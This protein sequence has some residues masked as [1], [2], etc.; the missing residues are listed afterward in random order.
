M[1]SAI[2]IDKLLGLITLQDLGRLHAQS[3]GFSASGACDENA[4][5]A[6]N[7]LIRNKPTTP[8]LE[9]ALL[10]ETI[11]SIENNCSII[12]TGADCKAKR[13]H[14]E[15]LIKQ[16]HWQILELTKGD[17]LILN[18][19]KRGVYSYIAIKGGINASIWLNSAS[20]N[21]NE[22][23]LSFT[24]PLLKVG[25]SVYQHNVSKVIAPFNK[26]TPIKKRGNSSAYS[27]KNF[28]TFNYRNEPLTL[29]FL[30]S[31]LFWQLPLRTQNHILK[32]MYK[33]DVRCNRMGVRIKAQEAIKFPKDMPMNTLSQP[34]TLGTVQ[35]PPD[36]FPIILMKDR[37]TI[38]GY[39]V[40]GS[41]IQVD[42]FRLSQCSPNQYIKLA[43]TDI[44]FAQTQLKSFYDRYLN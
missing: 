32:E 29:R 21:I 40:L 37:Q 15:E 6:A 38:G 24:P 5:L 7:V 25:D 9:I 19:P 18:K 13:L 34:V 10:G 26:N 28:Y 43:I 31:I 2:K 23:Q 22:V 17:K 4:Y 12:I 30:P 11:L 39:P 14:C 41:V 3:I 27:W 36:G 8:A 44:S 33:V 20:Q 16:P 1:H 42:T 35:L